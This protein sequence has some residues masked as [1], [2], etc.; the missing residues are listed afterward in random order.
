MHYTSIDMY[1]TSRCQLIWH[2]TSLV[3]HTVPKS[4]PMGAAAKT[5]PPPK[6]R[7]YCNLT[8][9]EPLALD[10]H[11]TSRTLWKQDTK[12]ETR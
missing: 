6:P 8:T 11:L 9:K 5:T 7:R 12:M 3:L 10:S 4:P 2:S 1:S